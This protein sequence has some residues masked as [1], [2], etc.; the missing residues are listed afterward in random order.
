MVMVKAFLSEGK[1]PRD[2]HNIFIV[3]HLAM[4]HISE[5][6]ALGRDFAKLW[7]ILRINSLPIILFPDI[8]RVEGWVF[9]ITLL[10][11]S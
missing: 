3:S 4:L 5:V 7:C 6:G 1:I 2:H 9:P 8:V 10:L 11:A